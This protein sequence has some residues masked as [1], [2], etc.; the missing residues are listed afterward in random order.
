LLAL[1]AFIFVIGI[2]LG[3]VGIGGVVMVPIITQ[4]TGIDIHIVVASTIFS[5][6][7]SGAVGTFMY[8][9]NGSI[10]W[11]MAGWL[12]AG[13]IIG[14]FAG[15]MLLARLSGILVESI[16]GVLVLFTGLHALLAKASESQTT[17]VGSKYTFLLVGTVTGVGSA[18]SGAGGPL[19][20][21]PILMWLKFPILA[22]VALGQFIQIPV[23]LSASVGNVLNGLLDIKLGL[24][25]SVCLMAGVV[26]GAKI[27]V[28][29]PAPVVKR[30]V[31]VVLVCMAVVILGRLAFG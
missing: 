19:L 28:A 15:T 31:A 22:A 5:A 11:S 23:A 21:V 13:A 9:R 14:A 25:I 2:L 17:F 16:V 3:A 7:F 4:L 30:V 12:G 29:L 6:I 10:Q 1:I 8:A 24:L 26:L 27:S 18:I 20:M